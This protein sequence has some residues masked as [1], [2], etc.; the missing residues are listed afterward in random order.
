MKTLATLTCLMLSVTACA[1]DSNESD[2]ALGGKADGLGDGPIELPEPGCPA[3]VDCVT[4]E[5]KPGQTAEVESIVA[6]SAGMVNVGYSYQPL[7]I[8]DGGQVEL[9]SPFCKPNPMMGWM[10]VAAESSLLDL[11]A[12]RDDQPASQMVVTAIKKKALTCKF[13]LRN[14]NDILTRRIKVFN[15]TVSINDGAIQPSPGPIA[16]P[17]VRPL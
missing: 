16:P 10:S 1:T 4:I 14:T 11:P 2:G 8:D 5:L 6:N 9:Q 12:E 3:L 13:T 7:P 15:G 17:P